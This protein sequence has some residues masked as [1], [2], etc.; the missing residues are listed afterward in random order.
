MAQL[1]AKPYPGFEQRK[2]ESH[3][4]YIQRTSALLSELEAASNALSGDDVEGGMIRFQVA[5]G[6][7]HY[8]VKKVKPL[9]LQHV[10]FL[11]GYA[12]SAAHIRGLRLVD[13]QEQLRMH[14]AY[15]QAFTRRANNAENP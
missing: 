9:T 13:V 14:R 10:P 8:F 5:D 11:D 1:T 2:D 15:A 4:A 7:A 12:V 6:Y 3:A